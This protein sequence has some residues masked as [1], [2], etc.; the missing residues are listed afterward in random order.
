[1]TVSGFGH[2]PSDHPLDRPRH[3]L[4]RLYRVGGEPSMREIARRTGHS[5]SHATVHTVLRCAKTPNWGP[6]ELVVEALDGNSEEFRRVW[7]AVRDME[8]A[9]RLDAHGLAGPDDS[10][11]RSATLAVQS[12]DVLAVNR[13]PDWGFED[14]AAAAMTGSVRPDVAMHAYLTNELSQLRSA[15]DHA[16]ARAVLAPVLTRYRS[17]RRSGLRR[18]VCFTRTCCR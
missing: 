3:Q 12:R 16:G 13:L 8:D 17:W 2:R 4:Q 11:E 6:L 1:M 10:T 14:R 15:E 18:T 7:I 9:T 5:I